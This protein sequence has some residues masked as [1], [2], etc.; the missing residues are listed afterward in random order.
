MNIPHAAITRLQQYAGDKNFETTMLELGSAFE[1]GEN[2]I[3]LDVIRLTPNQTADL[4]FSLES[5][6][7]YVDFDYGGAEMRIRWPDE[8]DS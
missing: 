6:G 4:I 3:Y 8:T 1:E 5:L 7:Y 2:N